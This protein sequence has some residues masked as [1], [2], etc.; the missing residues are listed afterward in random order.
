M[1]ENPKPLGG[2]YHNR[3]N[4][5]ENANTN[6]TMDQ[7]KTFWN[8]DIPQSEIAELDKTWGERVFKCQ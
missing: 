8:L 4:E 3:G 7:M 2:Y 6:L 5:G 1:A